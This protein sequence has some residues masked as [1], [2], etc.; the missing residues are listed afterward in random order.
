[1]NLYTEMRI[2]FARLLE[3]SYITAGNGGS[4][5]LERDGNTLTVFFE[6]SNGE[7]DW[8][9]NLDFPSV[10]Y[11]HMP[12]V[13]YCHRGFARVFGSLLPL[14]QNAL[15]D[16]TLS[17]I[18]VCGYSHGGALALLCH[19]FVW[20]ARPD[21]RGGKLHSFAF[22]APRVIFAPRGLC[23]GLKAR[24][25]DLVLVRNLDDAVTHLPPRFLGYT[26]P[27]PP[28]IIGERGK[29]SPVDAHRADA[30]LAELSAAEQ[31]AERR[32]K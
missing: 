9:N 29:Y 21:L 31:K 19:E 14:I 24:F 2:C 11:A 32:A 28:L 7:V 16:P 25:A 26:H 18:T 12:C 27:H 1:M 6:Q 3:A 4:Y 10:L 5:C 30:Y 15:L 8:L 20:Y 22:G 17:Q 23:P 13:W